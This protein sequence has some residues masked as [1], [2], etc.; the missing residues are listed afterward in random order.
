MNPDS[1]PEITGPAPEKT[2]P[3]KSQT[4]CASH[5]CERG[6]KLFLRKSRSVGKTVSAPSCCLPPLPGTKA[7]ELERTAEML[8]PIAARQGVYH[9][10]AF[11][12]DLQYGNAEL[13]LLLSYLE[14]M[15][16]AVLPTAREGALELAAVRG[17]AVPESL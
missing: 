16:G 3:G 2:N 12:A 6:G 14:S 15:P 7:A 8:V 11:L 5:P 17:M 9:V 4:A 13:R 1:G 10:V